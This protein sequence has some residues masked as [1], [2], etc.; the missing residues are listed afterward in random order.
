MPLSSGRMKEY[1]KRVQGPRRRAYAKL[2]PES[3]QTRAHNRG[4]PHDEHACPTCL[5]EMVLAAHARRMT[6][7]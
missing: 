2:W 5:H 1:G 6:C 7:A 4:L 3:P